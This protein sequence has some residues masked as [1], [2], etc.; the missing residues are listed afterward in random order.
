MI[1]SE[2]RLRAWC[3]FCDLCCAGGFGRWRLDHV[4][5]SDTVSSS[6]SL[7]LLNEIMKTHSDLIGECFR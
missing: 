7:F 2:E 6:H 4:K 3:W 5:R 1:S